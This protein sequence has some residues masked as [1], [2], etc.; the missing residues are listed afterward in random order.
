[1]CQKI[2]SLTLITWCMSHSLFTARAAWS[3]HHLL[4]VN[5]QKK[6]LLLLTTLKVSFPLLGQQKTVNKVNTYKGYV[7]V[8][9][10]KVSQYNDFDSD[11]INYFVKKVRK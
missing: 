10:N 9:F 4:P 3:S 7:T 2:S 6:I 5:R 11:L 8:R 1:M